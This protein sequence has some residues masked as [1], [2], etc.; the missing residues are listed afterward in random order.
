MMPYDAVLPATATA[1]WSAPRGGAMDHRR[2]PSRNQTD[3]LDT[4]LG[5]AAYF[6]KRNSRLT[7]RANKNRE[8][9]CQEVSAPPGTM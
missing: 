1:T 2:R 9:F 3:L 5:F 8:P 4:R 7:E 6:A